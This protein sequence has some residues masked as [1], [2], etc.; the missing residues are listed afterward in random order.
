MER[1]HSTKR[2]NQNK[3]KHLKVKKQAKCNIDIALK[4][5]K[6]AFQVKL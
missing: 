4:T 6:K 5:M 3:K 2:K 1:K